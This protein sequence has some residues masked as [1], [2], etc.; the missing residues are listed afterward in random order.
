MLSQ[1]LANKL[2][3][4]LNFNWLFPNYWCPYLILFIIIGDVC[5]SNK[6]SL[7]YPLRSLAYLKI[8]QECVDTL[9]GWKGWRLI[10]LKIFLRFRD[11]N[12]I[13]IAI[14]FE[15]FIFFKSELIF[16]MKKTPN[17]KSPINY[18]NVC[19]LS[20]NKLSKFF[21]MTATCFSGLCLDDDRHVCF[22]GKPNE[23]LLEQFSAR[24]F[25]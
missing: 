7:S 4:L 12:A 24:W 6:R 25:V 21:K 22:I 18:T 9:E 15:H 13:Y 8:L 2:L 20:Q 23:S 14:A 3:L 10:Q 5:I 11:V 16:L 17:I 19:S 1:T